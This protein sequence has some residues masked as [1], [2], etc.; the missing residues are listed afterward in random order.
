MVMPK[1]FNPKLQKPI[2]Q[3]LR[4]RMTR[5]EKILWYYLRGSSLE[6][7]KFRR[8]QGIGP[9]I[10]DFY[11]PEGNLA[12]ELDGDS[13]YQHGS[14]RRD[15]IKQKFIEEQGIRVIR[16]SDNDVRDSLPDVLAIILRELH[17]TPNPSSERRGKTTR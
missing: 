7:Y 12:V 2:R 9:Y 14:A 10:V 13:H 8:Q 11:C 1:L 3:G 5:A 17:T 6:R 4:N 15:Q 16:F